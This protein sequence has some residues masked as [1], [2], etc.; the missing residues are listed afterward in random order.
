MGPEQERLMK[1]LFENPDR[2]LINL[3]LFRGDKP[4]TAE[5]I[6]AELNK[7]LDVSEQRH[8][9]NKR[10]AGRKAPREEDHHFSED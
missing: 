4:A 8:R 1:R 6:C 7:M 10:F 3:K 9:L 5:Q 2:K